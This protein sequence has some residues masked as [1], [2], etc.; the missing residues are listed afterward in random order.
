M[1]INHDE[2][3]ALAVIRVSASSTSIDKLESLIPLTP[4]RKV[5]GKQSKAGES[6][7]IYES[8]SPSPSIEDHI[9]GLLT[10][11]EEHRSSFELLPR[12]CEIDIWCTIS[13][14]KEFSGFG[15]S[16]DLLR[17]AAEL[18]LQLVFGIYRGEDSKKH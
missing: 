13:T 18:R 16:R 12:D 15:L 2:E 14:S 10:L 1:Q 7:W 8:K 11:L 3:S 17:R 6:K 4:T 9:S 5:D